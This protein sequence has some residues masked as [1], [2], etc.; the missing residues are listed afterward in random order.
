[1]VYER[2]SI[3]FLLR[4]LPNSLPHHHSVPSLARSR[5]PPPLLGARPRPPPP[6]L[7]LKVYLQQK[8]AESELLRGGRGIRSGSSRGRLVGR[9][10]SQA[11]LD[12]R[13]PALGPSPAGPRCSWPLPQS[14]AWGRRCGES[15][16]PGWSRC[17]PQPQNL[18]PRL[19]NLG[20]G[21][22]PSSPAATRCGCRTKALGPRQ[23]RALGAGAQGG[24]AAAPRGQPPRSNYRHHGG[25]VTSAPTLS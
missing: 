7:C 13:N 11:D 3:L 21:L 24:L 19:I 12:C 6:F 10:A 4:L 22:R 8:G 1:M 17:D 9:F 2:S 20:S 5:S 15:G 23:L 18:D 16:R 14:W 25:R